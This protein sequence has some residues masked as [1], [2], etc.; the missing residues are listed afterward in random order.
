MALFLQCLVVFCFDNVSSVV[1]VLMLQLHLLTTLMLQN[2][3]VERV[4]SSPVVYLRSIPFS[5]DLSSLLVTVLHYVLF[6]F[7]S[8]IFKLW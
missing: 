6:S 1:T 4:F 7:L 8:I 5:P 3:E 2:W